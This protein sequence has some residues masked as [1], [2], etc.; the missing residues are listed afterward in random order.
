MGM[1]EPSIALGYIESGKSLTVARDAIGLMYGGEL[2]PHIFQESQLLN[3][4][5]WQPA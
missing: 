3:D 5:R 2:S 4:F 1:G